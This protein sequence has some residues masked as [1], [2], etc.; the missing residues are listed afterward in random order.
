[1]ESEFSQ[2]S[3]LCSLAFCNSIT[4]KVWKVGWSQGE[5]VGLSPV[6]SVESEVFEPSEAYDTDPIL[7]KFK[8][9]LR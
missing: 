9:I 1:M 7:G 2:C 8:L 6:G 5:D 4:G 3:H